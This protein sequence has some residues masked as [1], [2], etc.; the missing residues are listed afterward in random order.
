MSRKRLRSD[1]SICYLCSSEDKQEVLPDGWCLRCRRAIC[2]E[3]MPMCDAD[4]DCTAN[5]CTRCT[6]KCMGCEVLTC[7]RHAKHC[8]FCFDGT[9]C[10]CCVISCSSCGRYVCPKH[11]G[12]HRKVCERAPR[13]QR[14]IQLCA[15]DAC[16]CSCDDRIHKYFLSCSSNNLLDCVHTP[17]FGLRLVK[18]YRKALLPLDK[19]Q[20]LMRHC[21][22]QRECHLW[23]QLDTKKQIVKALLDS[24]NRLTSTTRNESLLYVMPCIA[25]ADFEA[26]RA[27]EY[28]PKLEFVALENDGCS[29]CSSKTLYFPLFELFEALPKAEKDALG[30]VSWCYMCDSGH[31]MLAA[32]STAKPL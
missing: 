2:S 21:H 6:K 26:I 17:E 5:Y 7:P 13:R 28:P 19:R 14:R 10:D 11:D 29:L 30:F 25:S 4:I 23:F 27:G 8:I 31:V 12:V 15:Y 24:I 32:T 3:H 16:G 18:K 1:D 22:N 20:A 9:G